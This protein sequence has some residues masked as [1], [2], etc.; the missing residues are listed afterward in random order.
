MA[1]EIPV[2]MKAELARWNA[3]KGIS[4][5]SWVGCTGNLNLAVGYCT[6]F[7]PKFEVVKDYILTEGWTHEGLA[8]FESQ[9]QST[10]KSVEWVLN[11][12]H[13]ADIHLNDDSPAAAD[14]LLFLGRT[15]RDVYAAKLAWEFP[16]RPCE[17][18]LYIPEVLD[19]LWEYQVSFWQKKWD[20]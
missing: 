1:Y 3:G 11:H 18:K 12:L 13:L 6:V 14:R 8:G 2:S 10:P 4:L 7:W 20:K 15:L 9:P 19:D 16:D 5:E 17:V